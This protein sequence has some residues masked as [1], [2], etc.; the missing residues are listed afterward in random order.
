[1]NVPQQ[2]VSANPAPQASWQMTTSVDVFRA[3]ST[4]SGLPNSVLLCRQPAG[5]NKARARHEPGSVRS[6]E[7]DTLRNVAGCAE[8]ANRMGRQR[9]LSRRIDVVRAE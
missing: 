6:E 8:P 4:G 5:Y 3:G 1:M 2:G 7:N 9:E